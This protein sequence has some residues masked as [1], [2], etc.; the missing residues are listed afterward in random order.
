MGHWPTL[1]AAA[2]GGSDPLLVPTTV[3]F[4]PTSSIFCSWWTRR[5]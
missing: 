4:P 2:P 5:R 3:P 1:D